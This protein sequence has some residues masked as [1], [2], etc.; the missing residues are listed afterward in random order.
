MKKILIAIINYKCEQEVLDYAINLSNQFCVGDIVLAIANNLSSTVSSIDL[1]YELTKI[2]IDSII[3]EPKSNLGYLNGVFFAF[4]AFKEKQGYLPDWLIVSNTDIIIEDAHFYEKFLSAK[5]DNDTW[6]IAPSVLSGDRTTYGNPHYKE[7]IPLKKVNRVIK[8]FKNNLLASIYMK[9]A[10]LKSSTQKSQ[11]QESQFVYSSHGCYFILRKEF[12]EY[13]NGEK[14][15]AFLYSEESYI[16][17]QILKAEK[18]EFY[19]SNLELIHNENLSTGKMKKKNK[20]NNIAQSMQY[21]KD[22]FYL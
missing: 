20:Y 22:K 9:L 15:G 4:D 12:Y 2:Q 3:Y 14:Y 13:L 1:K 10:G 18:K 19:D 6:C 16:A 11:K 8:I 17:E 7:R 5:Y 21:I